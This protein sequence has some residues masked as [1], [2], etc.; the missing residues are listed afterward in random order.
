MA[1]QKGKE[2]CR[3]F[4]REAVKP[5]LDRNFPGLR[6]SAGLLGYGSDVLGYDD[7]VSTDHM[8][9]PRLYLFLAEE[10]M[11][12]KGDV[13]NALCAEL[14]GEFGGHSVHFSEPD[15]D[16]NGVRH[17]EPAPAG[18]LPA[19]G[20]GA[21]GRSGKRPPFGEAGRPLPP[22]RGKPP[23]RPSPERKSVRPPRLKPLRASCGLRSKLRFGPKP[24]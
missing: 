16:D 1:F 24:K 7:P 23:C 22:C 8:W 9:G 17:P 10:E 15:P 21:P 14:P 5:I 4:Y 3:D 13:W 11:G 6:Y 2:L 12:K 20:R 19:P 18:R